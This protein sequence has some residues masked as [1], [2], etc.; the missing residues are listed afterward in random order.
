M[1]LDDE[2]HAARQVLR[3]AAKL[4]REAERYYQS[5]EWRAYYRDRPDHARP[6]P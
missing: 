2:I 3:E 5:L 6:V 1:T 4:H